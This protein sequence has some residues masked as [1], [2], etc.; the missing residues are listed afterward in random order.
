MGTFRAHCCNVVSIRSCRGC[1]ASRIS[2]CSCSAATALHVSCTS[3]G[4]QTE[5]S[6]NPWARDHVHTASCPVFIVVHSINQSSSSLSDANS[7]ILIVPSTSSSPPSTLPSHLISIVRSY[8]A[9][10][11][12]CFRIETL[13]CKDRNYGFPEDPR[14]VLAMTSQ[15]AASRVTHMAIN[16]VYLGESDTSLSSRAFSLDATQPCRD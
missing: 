11:L 2:F 12:P 3:P 13:A 9:S 1:R 5:N 8:I 15:R 16:F 6:G 4:G 10:F 7:P 14:N